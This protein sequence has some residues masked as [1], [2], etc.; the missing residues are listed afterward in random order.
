MLNM[1]NLVFK[2]KPVKNLM[3]WYIE[4]YVA[5]KVVLKNAVKLKLLASIRIHPVVNV[6]RVVRYREPVKE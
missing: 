2:E 1:K 4:P 5:E 3:E 6:S